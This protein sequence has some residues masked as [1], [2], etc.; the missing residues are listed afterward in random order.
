MARWRLKSAHYLNVPGTDVTFIEVSQDTGRQAKKTYPVP[1]YLNP[2]DASDWNYPQE[3]IIVVAQGKGMP[4]DIIFEG[5]PTPDMEPM[6]E[7]AQAITDKWR[8]KWVHPIE[9][10]EG[11]YAD[12][13][14]RSLEAQMQRGQA[15]SVGVPQDKFDELK[16]QVEQ[17][18][19][20]NSQLIEQLAKPA[21]RRV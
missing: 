2:N 1:R 7:E 19:K 5:P 17:L 14:W 6:D 12:Q 21:G 8:D 13:I 9:G 3:G 10:L 4:R 20:Q 16:T 18:M 15:A 11:S